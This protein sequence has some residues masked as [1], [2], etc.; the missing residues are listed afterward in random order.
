M[1]EEERGQGLLNQVSQRWAD[2]GLCSTRLASQH[3]PGLVLGPRPGP[4]FSLSAEGDT[5]VDG[6]HLV[7]DRDRP[8]CASGKAL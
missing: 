1:A 7:H 8:T 3:G 5:T 6:V 2:I 4:P